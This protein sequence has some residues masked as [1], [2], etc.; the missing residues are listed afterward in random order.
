MFI[1]QATKADS[2]SIAELALMAGGGISG[3]FWKKQQRSGQTLIEVGAKRAEQEEGH[4]SYK[5]VHVAEHDGE[6]AGML[7]GYRMP[8]MSD[9]DAFEGMP[10][11]VKPIIEVEQ[12]AAGSYYICKLATYPQHRKKGVGTRLMGLVDELAK[13]ADGTHLSLAVFEQNV[14]ALRL[15]EHLGF[16]EAA[17][18]ALMPHPYMPYDG[19]VLLVTRPLAA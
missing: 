11:F 4:S 16:R 19:D 13:Q 3:Y 14:N 5:N 15:Y 6:V 12:K 10:D 1:R 18:A 7:L 17:R 2:H 9:E 8:T